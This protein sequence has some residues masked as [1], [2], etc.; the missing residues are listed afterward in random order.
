MHA[1]SNART[2]AGF[3]FDEIPELD[4]EEVAEWLEGI[5]SAEEEQEQG[6]A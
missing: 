3:E 2:H 4:K 6:P 5:R 1:R